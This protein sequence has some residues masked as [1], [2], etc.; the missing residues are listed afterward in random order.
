MPRPLVI[1][2]LVSDQA[3]RSLNAWHRFGFLFTKKS[4]AARILNQPIRKRPLLDRASDLPRLLR[5]P[6]G[7]DTKTHK[8]SS[9]LI[10]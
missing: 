1:N 8:P 9:S 2:L 7:T 6:T 4:L 10:Q 3:L 5:I